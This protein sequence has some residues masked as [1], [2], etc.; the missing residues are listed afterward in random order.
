MLVTLTSSCLSLQPPHTSHPNLIMLV[1]HRACHSNLVILVTLTSS[2]LPLKPPHT[3]HSNLLM[4]VRPT[5][6]E[7]VPPEL[8]LSTPLAPNRPQGA[9]GVVL[10]RSRQLC[11]Q[12]YEKEMFRDDG[13]R[14]AAERW[15]LNLTAKQLAI[16]AALYAWRDRVAREE[17]ESTGVVTPW[18]HKVTPV[19]H[20]H[21]SV[22]SALFDVHSWWCDCVGCFV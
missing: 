13:Y 22:W 6:G 2:C 10:E 20:N 17:D 1:T 21:T 14:E 4:L 18:S 8:L 19:S 15:R 5:P 9:L 11:M 12:L 3:C 16:F 7:V